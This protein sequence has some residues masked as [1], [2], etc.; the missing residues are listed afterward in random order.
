MHRDA[1]KRRVV[2]RLKDWHWSRF[3]FYAK[4]DSGLARIDSLR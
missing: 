4:R 1:V 2:S 3:S